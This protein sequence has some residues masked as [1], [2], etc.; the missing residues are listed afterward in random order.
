M[1]SIATLPT[2]LLRFHLYH[3]WCSGIYF[4]ECYSFSTPSFYKLFYS[5]Y[6][7]DKK[8]ACNS[9]DPGSIPGLGKSPG[10]G[11]TPVFLPGKSH[12][13]RN[14]AGYSPWCLKD[15][16]LIWRHIF[17]YF[18]SFSNLQGWLFTNAAC[19]LTLKKIKDRKNPLNHYFLT[20]NTFPMIAKGKP[21]TIPKQQQSVCTSSFIPDSNPISFQLRESTSDI[22]FQFYG[23]QVLYFSKELILGRSS[24][25]LCLGLSKTYPVPVFESQAWTLLGPAKGTAGHRRRIYWL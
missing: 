10:E 13:W 14:L 23:I 12:G 17:F 25:V 11:N 24:C 2:P 3:K 21:W 6:G 7:D 19:H 1:T 16:F 18:L 5:L 22:C 15:P 9:G 8:S 4:L 20:N